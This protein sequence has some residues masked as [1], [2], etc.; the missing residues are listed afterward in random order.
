METVE[1]LATGLRRWGFR[2]IGFR[3]LG[4]PAKPPGSLVVELRVGIADDDLND[5]S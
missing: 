3:G 1:A 2:A 4:L 5:T